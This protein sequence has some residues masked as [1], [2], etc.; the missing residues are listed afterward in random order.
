MAE[1]TF[2]GINRVTGQFT[3]SFSSGE[4]NLV[5]ASPSQTDDPSTQPVFQI[6][7]SSSSDPGLK[8]FSNT[9][10]LTKDTTEPDTK[11]KWEFRSDFTSGN[12]QTYCFTET[13]SGTSSLVTQDDTTK[14]ISAD[15]VTDLSYGLL[16]QVK[17]LDLT[18]TGE[19]NMFTT[20]SSATATPLGFG[21]RISAVSGF[22]SLPK[23]RFIYDTDDKPLTGTLTPFGCDSVDDVFYFPVTGGKTAKV[24]ASTAVKIDITEAA[25]AT[26]LEATAFAVGSTNS[27]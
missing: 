18:A 2:G 1:F 10:S 19:F 9:Y 13:S 11:L 8:L 20:S 14:E 6:N 23:F 17:N 16:G 7:T 25:V 24:P 12:T 5:Y 15:G 27:F 3:N 22:T 26:T 21:L 4:T